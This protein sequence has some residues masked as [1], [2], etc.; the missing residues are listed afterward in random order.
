MNSDA[1]KPISAQ[2][3]QPWQSIM[4]VWVG[5]SI[6]MGSLISG[7]KLAETNTL[8]WA[9]IAG[10]IGYSLIS[11][12]SILMGTQGSDTGLPT[13]VLARKTFGE[14]YARY[15]FSSILSI[16]LI[17]WFGIQGEVAGKAILG[18]LADYGVDA[19]LWLLTLISGVLMTL[20]AMYGIKAMKYLNY[21]AV[22]FMV[23]VILWATVNA[24]LDNDIEALFQY[25]PP[26]PV[27][28]STLVS[29]IALITGSFIIG[30]VIASDYTRYNRTRKDTMKATFYGIV[31]IGMILK[32]IGA[33]LA[34]LF[35]AQN[36]HD[37]INIYQIF[38]TYVDNSTVVFLMVLLACWTTNV[39]NSYSGGLAIANGFNINN[40][41]H[42]YTIAFAGTIG[43]LLSIIGILKSIVPFLLLLTA[44]VA[45]LA[46]VM[47][48][49]YWIKNK[50]NAQRFLT[51][52]SHSNQAL[53]A[54]ICG[55]SPYILSKFIPSLHISQYV[56]ILGIILSM[57][58]YLLLTKSSHLST[59]DQ[60]A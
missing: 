56:S 4:F 34:M 43:T 55:C 46:G 42:R 10:I 35:F 17:G 26:Q 18:Y 37:G 20:T 52:K 60:H 59:E 13:T 2:E 23:F 36:S 12:I 9:L 50:G 33:S 1:I 32:L 30:C 16:A 44:L 40:Q 5:T 29:S 19:P 21:V 49:D 57:S 3:K 47:I 7:I 38:N 25:A 31:P 41:Y 6:S 22:P 8:F 28:L 24:F 14:K 58:V 53:I 45:P 27:T 39:G 15:L 11:L 48:A 54:W 51:K